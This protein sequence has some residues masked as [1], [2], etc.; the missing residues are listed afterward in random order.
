MEVYEDCIRKYSKDANWIGFIDI[1]EFI[2]LRED[3]PG[4]IDVLKPFSE[5]GSVV[6][7]WRVYGSSGF[8]KRDT[9]NPVVK[10]F[11]SCLSKFWIN[12][13]CF[14][15]T[16]YLFKREN[17][18]DGSFHHRIWGEYN[19]KALPPVN[20]YD[21]FSYRTFNIADDAFPAAWINHYCIKSLNEYQERLQKGMFFM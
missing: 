4:I 10:D 3:I 1:D 14:F 20:C 16:A 19:G 8:T 9:A 15:N 7:Y 21:H 6:L 5:R 11:Q 2:M 12:G 17:Q 13:K 18:M